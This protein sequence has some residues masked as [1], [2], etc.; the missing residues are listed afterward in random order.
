MNTI[1][2]FIK[3]PWA[4]V[5][6]I[7]WLFVVYLGWHKAPFALVRKQLGIGKDA[8]AGTTKDV[9][10]RSVQQRPGDNTVPFFENRGE[11]QDIVEYVHQFEVVWAMW[12]TAAHADE[13]DVW[14]EKRIKKLILIDPNSSYL[15]L[16][17]VSFG[18]TANELGPRIKDAT[19][20]AQQEGTIVK[21]FTGPIA[22]A[23]TIGNPETNPRI[24][25]EPLILYT[26]A[27][28]RQ[29]YQV[30]AR[31]RKS[32]QILVNEFNKVWKDSADP[33]GL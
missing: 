3:S 31:H 22:S 23:L 30:D 7:A 25:V 5:L 11:L 26:N 15:A 20:H 18:R 4:I 13:R 29:S 24:L 19:R 8:P 16:Q 2:E 28:D 6:A 21:W 33:Y 14:K 12:H 1:T 17:S 32:A 10:K 9:S 27:N